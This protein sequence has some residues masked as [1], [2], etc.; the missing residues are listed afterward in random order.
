MRSL[1]YIVATAAAGMV[2]LLSQAA[3]STSADAGSCARASSHH[4]VMSHHHAMPKPKV[5]HHH[6]K[7]K[8]KVV[9]HHHKPKPKVMHH[10]HKPAPKVVHHHHKP[11]PKV[12]HH[13]HHVKAAPPARPGGCGTFKYYKGGKCLDARN[14]K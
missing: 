7:P 6:H 10:H 13:H 5:M 12:A 2:G 1:R 11:A 4:A 14:K 9:H 3:M 8:P